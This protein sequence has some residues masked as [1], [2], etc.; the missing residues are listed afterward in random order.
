MVIRCTKLNQE[1]TITFEYNMDIVANVTADYQNQ[2]LI[3]DGRVL[4]EADD[5][6]SALIKNSAQATVFEK[7]IKSKL[8]GEF[9]FEVPIVSEASDIYEI[10]IK[11]K[12]KG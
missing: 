1:I 10:T 11:H 3:I 8:Y 9:L 2:K 6:V 4:G 5:T 12:E 7:D